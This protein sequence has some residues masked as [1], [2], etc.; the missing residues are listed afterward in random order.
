MEEK[1]TLSTPIG[2][3]D[4]LHN[5]RKVSDGSIRVRG[6]PE[7]HSWN[8]VLVNKSVDGVLKNRI[9][10]KLD[11]Y[12]EKQLRNG[13][14]NRMQTFEVWKAK[15]LAQKHGK[16]EKIPFIEV[17][18][19]VGDKF[20]ACPY[21][22]LVNEKG[23]PVGKSGTPIPSWD[24]RRRYTEARGKDGKPI[25]SRTCK[26]LKS[27]YRDILK[28]IQADNPDMVVVCAAIHAD[29]YGGVHMHV[30]LIPFSFNTKQGIGVSIAPTTYYKEWCK[31]R[32]IKFSKDS[33]KDCAANKWREHLRSTCEGVMND[34]GIGL[35]DGKAAGRPHMSIEQYG[36][37][38]D[39]K[40][41]EQEAKNKA[42]E[43]KVR[44]L[45]GDA[46]VKSKEADTKKAQADK[47][48][49]EAIQIKEEAQ[50]MR[51]EFSSLRN[52]YAQKVAEFNRLQKE[53][54]ACADEYR[55]KLGYCQSE[56]ARLKRLSETVDARL[57]EATKKL[58]QEEALRES[59]E[60]FAKSIKANNEW[61]KESL[62]D[63]ER[64]EAELAKR[65]SE[66]ESKLNEMAKQEAVFLEVIR[67]YPEI[68]EELEE[69]HN[70]RI[71]YDKDNKKV[72]IKE[73]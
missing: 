12:N 24:T 50:R 9:R 46:Q 8:E 40:C 29:E 47:A 52:E 69:R 20:S 45:Y 26:V 34:Y 16:K 56:E 17:V 51:D 62:A 44:K 39:G 70:V 4:I 6:V 65:N 13:R 14:P 72:I 38:K 43:V 64:R 3:G 32:Y 28:K 54:Q 49:A 57:R 60:S 1:M 36:E 67:R 5:L 41:E 31:K 58:E 7:R 23:E 68:V 19:Q 53:A 2:R 35:K 37:W 15:Q 66:L 18:I 11:E 30:D 10:W 25:E 27:V 42:F 22:Y 48:M 61:V 55:T 21:V 33:R 71:V 73:R 63:V 59:N